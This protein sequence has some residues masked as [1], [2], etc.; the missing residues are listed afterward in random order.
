MPENGTETSSPSA[1]TF[2]PPTIPTAPID[3]Q[4]PLLDRG[5]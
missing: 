2:L 5:V 3:R 4:T 1:A